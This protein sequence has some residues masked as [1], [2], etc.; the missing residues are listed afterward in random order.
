MNNAH[1]IKTVGSSA[2]GGA[3]IVLLV[4]PARNNL[5]LEQFSQSIYL[6]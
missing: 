4:A 3:P 6:G 5:P 1:E 2:R